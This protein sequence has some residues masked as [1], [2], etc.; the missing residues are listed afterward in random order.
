MS[1]NSIKANSGLTLPPVDPSTIVDPEIGDI[2]VD[3]TDSNRVKTWNGFFWSAVAGAEDIDVV[4][5][6]ADFVAEYDK[7]FVIANSGLINVTLPVPVANKTIKIKKLGSNLVSL[8]RSGSEKIDDIAAN[9]V[10]T[11]TKESVTLI[12]DGVDWFII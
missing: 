3:S 5:K 11:S 4:S 10:L 8:I 12:S 6:S 1:K 2:L 9:K 7:L